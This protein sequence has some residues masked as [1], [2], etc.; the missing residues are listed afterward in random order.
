MGVGV[1]SL[2]RKARR[3]LQR[4]GWA[5]GQKHD[6]G[7]SAAAGVRLLIGRSDGSALELPIRV[8]KCPQPCD[9]SASPPLLVH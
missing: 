9:A 2:D 4:P 3:G 7:T 8:R 6:D 1:E 5:A